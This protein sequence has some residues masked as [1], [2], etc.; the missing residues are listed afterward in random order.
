MPDR[1]SACAQSWPHGPSGKRALRSVALEIPISPV[2][3]LSSSRTRK[4]APANDSAQTSSEAIT[5]GLVG[6]NSVK[7]SKIAPSQKTRMIRNG[8]GIAPPACVNKSSR[9]CA[10]SVK[11]AMARDCSE[12][13]TCRRYRPAA[14]HPQPV[15][16]SMSHVGFRSKAEVGLPDWRV[17]FALKNGHAATAGRGVFQESRTSPKATCPRF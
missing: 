2:K 11:A 9:V 4:I 3:G 1:Q 12:R 17:G 15:D 5:T 13:C 6:A 16:T 10:P 7:L 8:V 14:R